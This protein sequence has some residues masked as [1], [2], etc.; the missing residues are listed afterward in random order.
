M[1]VE[2]QRYTPQA[3]ATLPAKIQYARELANSGLLPA[4]YRRN[5]AN[6]LYA[7]EYGEMLNLPAMA[8]IVG[9]NIID[10]KPSASAALISALVR[11]AG[12]KL[13][14]KGDDT[15]AVAQII[16]CDDPDFVYEAVWTMERAQ[17]AGLT[18]RSAWRQYPAA[19]LKARAI[20]EVARDACEEA[21]CGVHYTPEELGAEVDEDGNVITPP[22][23]PQA[24]QAAPQQPAEV[25]AAEDLDPGTDPAWLDSAIERAS[26]FATLDEGRALWVEITDRLHSGDCT[27]ADA[28]RLKGLITAR[29]EDLKATQET[30]EQDG[31]EAEPPADGDPVDAELVDGEGWEAA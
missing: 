22:S 27:Q 13:R 30:A 3:A 17:R 23:Q 6:V 10:G 21:L 26:S 8:A 4:A 24:P 29:V 18:N 5:P 15:R 31:Q 28:D 2:L 9:I 11:R 20:T 1:T 19:M 25:A 16:R 7:I 14:V 12:H